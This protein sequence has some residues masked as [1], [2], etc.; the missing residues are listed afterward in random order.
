MHCSAVSYWFTVFDDLWTRNFEM[1]VLVDKSEE[2]GSTQPS[3][4]VYN[5]VPRDELETFLKTNNLLDSAPKYFHDEL[6]SKLYRQMDQAHL[7][8]NLTEAVK[9]QLQ[10]PDHEP[11]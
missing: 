4:I 1:A 3:S 11:Q 6:L 9:Q 8:Y 2:F 10:G 5:P 7:S